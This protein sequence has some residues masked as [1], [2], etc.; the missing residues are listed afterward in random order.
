MQ[1]QAKKSLGQHFLIDE[2]I[3]RRIAESADIRD[4]ESVVE[5]GPGTGLLTK[6]LLAMP[7]AKLT[8][9]ELD[10]RA[11]P[12][13]ESEYHDERFSVVHQDFLEVPLN[14]FSVSGKINIIGN[15]PYYIT[16]P[17]VFKLLEERE[18]LRFA[19]ML[20][21]LEV[22]ERLI[23]VPR[24]KAYGI[25][26]VLT[27]CFAEVKML[28]KVKAGAFRPA[29]NVD[30]AVLR[31]DFENDFFTREKILPPRNF[32]DKKFSRLVR[33]LF[34]MRRKTIKNNLKALDISNADESKLALFLPKRAEELSVK[35]FLEFYR[36]LYS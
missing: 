22:A 34:A 1:L 26:S 6:H 32:D 19:T 28:F 24:T 23:G 29:P 18:S 3:L 5:I 15:I 7:L 2:N 20:V 33:T 30:S 36:M 21:Q 11:I 17:I 12:I 13:L 16:S 8:A 27:Q 14:D 4:G 9:F 25:P 10:E 35:E 31:F